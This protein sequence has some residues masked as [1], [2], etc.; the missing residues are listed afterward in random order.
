[1]K[2]IP[3]IIE[4]ERLEDKEDLWK[5]R[6]NTEITI[7]LSTETL[8]RVLVRQTYIPSFRMPLRLSDLTPL[9]NGL[10]NK[11]QSREQILTK[12][13]YILVKFNAL[14]HMHYCTFDKRLHLFTILN[15]NKDDDYYLFETVIKLDTEDENVLVSYYYNN[16]NDENSVLEN[17]P[18][19]PVNIKSLKNIIV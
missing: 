12:L 3:K 7:F 1:M 6:L 18:W 16:Y 13:N 14:D 8:Y 2:K 9:I 10:I 15:N 5:V 17:T 19:M 11:G 4:I